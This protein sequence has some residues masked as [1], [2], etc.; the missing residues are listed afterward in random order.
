MENASKA[1]IIAGAI[2]ISI[3]LISIGIMVIQSAQGVVDSAGSSMDAQTKQAFNAQFSNYSGTQ[4]GSSIR[5]MI[6]A[7]IASNA[8][9]GAEGGP[10]V[11]INGQEGDGISSLLTNIKNSA[12]YNVDIKIDSKTGLTTEIT[13]V[14]QS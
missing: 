10:T 4:R 2:L 14:A 5:A 7:V 9:Y 12:Q 3:L 8:S 11:K 13:F 1:L 6:N